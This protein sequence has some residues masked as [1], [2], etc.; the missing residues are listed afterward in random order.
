MQVFLATTLMLSFYHQASA[1]EGSFIE[2]TKSRHSETLGDIYTFGIYSTLAGNSAT[3]IY[4]GL[5]LMELEYDDL[6]TYNSTIK[7]F[8]GQAFG[9]T[10]APFYEIG[11]DLYGLLTLLDNDK[12]T[13]SCTADRECA[14]D[15]FFRLGIRINLGDNLSIGVFH[16]NIDFGDFHT[17]LSGEHQYVGSS[18]AFRF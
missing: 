16:E 3:K 5:Q 7:V 8:F 14:I 11:T 17:S 1:N 4:S 10:F 2:L 9:H 12:E 6:G 18:I 13:H 15:F